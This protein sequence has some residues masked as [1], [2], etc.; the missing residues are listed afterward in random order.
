MCVTYDGDTPSLKENVE[1]V[2]CVEGVS[3]CVCVCVLYQPHYSC[4]AGVMA[5]PPHLMFIFIT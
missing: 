4:P 1:G 5:A 3:E 2:C